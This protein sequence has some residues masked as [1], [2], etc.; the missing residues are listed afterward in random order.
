MRKY[1]LNCCM[2]V[3]LF[4]LAGCTT[5]IGADKVSPRQAYQHLHQN[6]LNS[7][8]CS[9]DTMRVL[10]RYDLDEAFRKDPDATLAKLQSIACTDDRRDLLYALSEL[11]YFNADRQS[12]S[13]KPGVPKYAR[14]SY[15]ASAIYAYLYLFG[16]G[17]P[18]S[19]FDIRV[20]VA[21]DLYNRGLA[22]GLMVGTNALVEM[23]RR[24]APDAARRGGSA[25]HAAGVSVEPRFDQGV[26]FRR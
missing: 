1:L 4:A 3:V 26:L 14:N 23:D 24:S 6:A 11:N 13:V 22:Q 7:S 21:A 19:P 25:V 9:A 16:E 10:N 5:P 18:P 17:E 8:Q 15:F 20:R 2:A 12:R